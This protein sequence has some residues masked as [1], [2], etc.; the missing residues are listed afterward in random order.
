MGNVVDARQ[1]PPWSRLV[2]TG[3]ESGRGARPGRQN[4]P[5]G[6]AARARGLGAGRWAG[7][8]GYVLLCL[9]VVGLVLPPLGYLVWGAFHAGG[10]GSEGAL[11]LATLEK[12]FASGTILKPLRNTLMLSALVA[13]C[14]VVLGAALAFI[15]AQTDVPGRR[16]WE[17]LLSTPFYIAPIF[18]T[19]ALIA[20]AGQP[21][22]AAPVF[23]ALGLGQGPDIY[24]FWGTVIVLTGTWSA[25]SFLYL[26]GAMRTVNWEYYE[27]ATLLGAS[28]ARALWDVAGKML[29]PTL[30]ANFIMIFALV[31][32]VFSVPDL[33][34][35][36]KN[37]TLAVDIFTDVTYE[38]TNLSDAASKGLLLVI[39]TAGLVAYGRL[40]R[41][42]ERYVSVSGKHRFRELMPL[43]RLRW[44]TAIGLGLY[45]VLA[46]VV[47]IL[48]LVAASLQPFIQP[49][50]SLSNLTMAN[51]DQAFSGSNILPLENTALLVIMG[52]IALVLLAYTVNYFVS[53]TGARFRNVLLFGSTAL[54]AMPGMALGVGMLYAYVQ[55]PVYGTVWVLFIAYVSRWM[56][57]AVSLLRGSFLP[58]GQELVESARMLGAG[59][60]HRL[61]SIVFPLTRRAAVSAWMVVAVLILG[62]VPV[63][64]LLYSPSSEPLSM[65]AWNDLSGGGPPNPAAVF[66]VLATVLG[67]GTMAVLTLLGGRRGEV[68]TSGRAG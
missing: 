10:P 11:T 23:S 68:G 16:A 55:V 24:S 8:G 22:Y 42:A 56:P 37:A 45:F 44:P 41:R 54:V 13:V 21:G 53:F 63:T 14:A 35:G 6:G 15:V 27:A 43:K 9:I 59:P 32:E 29:A 18:M 4:A 40:A 67:L 60:G 58:L 46:T 47:P 17:V 49:S 64:V 19:L 2:G 30:L 5:G 38:P 52:S 26:S 3:A 57:Q 25:Y 65:V 36:T 62:E 20:V 12:T 7:R 33:L 51:Y 1:R 61:R 48:S 31:S 28:R 34:W 66:A 39:T 50:L